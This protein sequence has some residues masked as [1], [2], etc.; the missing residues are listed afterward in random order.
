MEGGFCHDLGGGGFRVMV[1]GCF[2]ASLLCGG[3]KKMWW[4]LDLGGGK[5][6]RGFILSFILTLKC[7]FRALEKE[8]GTFVFDQIWDN[9]RNV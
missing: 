4:C 5:S 1:A 7:I 3:I 9:S 8:K 2:F 6:W